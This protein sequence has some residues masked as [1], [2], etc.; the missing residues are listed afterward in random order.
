MSERVCILMD[1]VQTWLTPREAEDYI[2]SLHAELAEAQAM[3]REAWEDN[4][5]LPFDDWLAD[6]RRRCHAH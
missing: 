5:V 1:G 6:L 3:L 2:S 4:D